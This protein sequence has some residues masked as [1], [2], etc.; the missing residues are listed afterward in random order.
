MFNRHFATKASS[1]S[2]DF[3]AFLLKCNE[4]QFW[5]KFRFDRGLKCMDMA[6]LMMVDWDPI[7]PGDEPDDHYTISSKEEV[8]EI[9]K[10]RV[11]SHPAELWRVYETPS[12]GVHAFLLSHSL[13]PE[14]G[15]GILLEMKGDLLYRDFSLKRGMWGVR[16]SPKP[17][18]VGD[19][20]ARYVA[21][22][23]SGK[24]LSEH[25]ET[26]KVHDSFLP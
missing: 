23:G 13:T 5:G 2:S 4:I 15:E 19:F 25:I 14:E 10:Q 9:I 20:V 8:Y 16:I 1:T 22:F 11:T 18:R 7:K 17:N 6:N 3:V 21:T 12:G 24:A 26:M